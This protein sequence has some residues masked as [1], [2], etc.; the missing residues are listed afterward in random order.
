MRKDMRNHGMRKG[1]RK[2]MRHGVEHMCAFS[3]DV[4][5]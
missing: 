4:P 2:G 5:A 1:M 3:P